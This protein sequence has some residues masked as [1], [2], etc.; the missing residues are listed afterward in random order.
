MKFLRSAIAKVQVDAVKR[1]IGY[2]YDSDHRIVESLLGHQGS[3]ADR[4]DKPM[5]LTLA[6]V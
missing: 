1:D 4:F 6:L 3:G 2:G 5:V